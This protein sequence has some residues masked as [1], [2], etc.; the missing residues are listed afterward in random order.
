MVRIKDSSHIPQWLEW[1]RNI[2]I[3][4]ILKTGIPLEGSGKIY[5][6]EEMGKNDSTTYAVDYHFVSK[7]AL[8]SYRGKHGATLGKEYEDEGWAD[9]TEVTRFIVS[10]A[11]IPSM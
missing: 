5:L 4:H 9:K 10:T 3:P 2:H 11:A 7:D 8:Q 1:M 6:V